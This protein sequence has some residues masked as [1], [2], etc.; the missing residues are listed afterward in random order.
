MGNFSSQ[1]RVLDVFKNI[2]VN[3]VL[4]DLFDDTPNELRT[5]SELDEWWDR[6]YALLQPDGTYTVRVLNG[7]AWDRS[8]YLGTADS[9][10]VACELAATAQAEWVKLR[11]Q[12]TFMYSSSAPYILI[13]MPQRPD[14][15]PTEVARF[16]TIEEL[17]DYLTST[18]K[19]SH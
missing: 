3:P 1:R 2:P 14:Q 16:D 7:G 19:N 10:E 11:S 6:P 8:T 12:P 17:N 15:E 9:Y 4:P 13:R 5:T 18:G